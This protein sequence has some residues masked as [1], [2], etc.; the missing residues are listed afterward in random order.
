MVVLERMSGQSLR[1]GPYTLEVLA[2]RAGEVVV[3]L[4]GPEESCAGCGR[5]AGRRHCPACGAEGAVCPECLPSC[6]CP[7]CASPWVSG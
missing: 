4:H 2:V 6:R 3:A 5:P 1:V 7:S